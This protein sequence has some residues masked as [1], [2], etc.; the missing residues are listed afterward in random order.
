MHHIGEVQEFEKY[1]LLSLRNSEKLKHEGLEIL[2]SPLFTYF[3][4]LI[5]LEFFP[6]RNDL[7]VY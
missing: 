7:D 3:I 4:F 2:P 5:L 1:G 6:F